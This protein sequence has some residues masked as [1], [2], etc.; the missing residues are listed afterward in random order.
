MHCGSVEGYGVE[1]DKESGREG[2][3]EEMVNNGE[4]RCMTVWPTSGPYQI[5]NEL[6]II[7]IATIIVFLHCTSMII[8]TLHTWSFPVSKWIYHFYYCCPTAISLIY[9]TLKTYST[10]YT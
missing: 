5:I 2:R 4:C 7:I 3:L 8:T 10:S 1:G 6:A 9:L